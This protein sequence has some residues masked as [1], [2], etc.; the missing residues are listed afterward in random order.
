MPIRDLT[1]QTVKN[2]AK[3]NEFDTELDFYCEN[4]TIHADS[5][6]DFSNSKKSR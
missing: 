3:A 5:R 1:F 4:V 2:R 6:S